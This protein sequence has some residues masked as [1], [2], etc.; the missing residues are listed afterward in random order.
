M[1]IETIKEAARLIQ[2]RVETLVSM[3]Y[4]GEYHLDGFEFAEKQLFITIRDC[5]RYAEPSD[6]YDESISFEELIL[7]NGEFI[8]R[9]NCKIEQRKKQEERERVY[10]ERRIKEYQERRDRAE[11]ER[12][13]KKLGVED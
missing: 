5:H 10:Q 4:P 8:D 7:D 11:L 1:D 9:I 12:L 6:T 2:D 3:M 13:K